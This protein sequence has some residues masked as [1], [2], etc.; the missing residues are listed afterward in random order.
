MNNQIKEAIEV[1]KRVIAL[2]LV[3]VVMFGGATLAPLPEPV[4]AH[5]KYECTKRD[6]CS[7]LTG[8]VT[9]YWC[10]CVDHVHGGIDGG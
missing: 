3:A 1:I 4:S 8:C 5:K 2:L 10:K 6:V 7:I 9:K